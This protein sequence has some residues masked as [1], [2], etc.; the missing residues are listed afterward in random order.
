MPGGF[1]PPQG[2]SDSGGVRSSEENLSRREKPSHPPGS[3]KI[4]AIREWGKPSHPGV[5]KP[6]LGELRRRAGKAELP[7]HGAR[8]AAGQPRAGRADTRRGCGTGR[9]RCVWPRAEWRRRPEPGE[10]AAELGGCSSPDP[11]DFSPC[12]YVPE[13]LPPYSLIGPYLL[14]PRDQGHPRPPGKEENL[15]GPCVC[16]WDLNILR[17]DCI[18]YLWIPCKSLW[19]TD[20]YNKGP[21][22][23]LTLDISSSDSG[24]NSGGSGCPRSPCPDRWGRAGAAE[25]MASGLGQLFGR[26]VS[27]PGSGLARDGLERASEPKAFH[28]PGGAE[29]A[30]CCLLRGRGFSALPSLSVRSRSVVPGREPKRLCRRSVSPGSE[31]PGQGMRGTIVSPRGCWFLLLGR[32]TPSRSC[33]APAA[34]GSCQAL[35]APVPA[36]SW[37]AAA[38]EPQ[39]PGLRR[40]QSSRR[41]RLSPQLLPHLWAAGTAQPE[42]APPC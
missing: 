33:P 36:R 11:S 28:V 3:G 22:C 27:V 25:V 29:S 6:G 5:G 7:P 32:R 13:P 10:A 15:D 39:G 8:D 26:E 4:R 12:S 1:A 20:I 35:S 9:S 42:L 23:F 17:A 18:K 37:A 34:S 30:A 40:P 2:R 38:A 16:A 14:L 41:L 31:P 24:R 19:F 21:L